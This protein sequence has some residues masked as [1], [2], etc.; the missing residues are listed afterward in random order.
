[1]KKF[2]L[3]LLFLASATLLNAQVAVTVSSSPPEGGSTVPQSG[4][5]YQVEQG[6]E[7]AL[8]AAPADLY[9]FDYWQIDGDAVF[10]DGTKVSTTASSTMIPNGQAT[11]TAYFVRHVAT[12]EIVVYDWLAKGRRFEGANNGAFNL[13]KYPVY[14]WLVMSFDPSLNVFSGAK[15]I[16][17]WKEDKNKYWRAGSITGATIDVIQDANRLQR[18]YIRSFQNGSNQKEGDFISSGVMELAKRDVTGGTVQFLLAKEMK[19]YLTFYTKDSLD[20]Q[21]YGSEYVELKFDS[22]RT[23]LG[24]IDNGGDLN[25][26]VADLSQRLRSKGFVEQQ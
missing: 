20:L 16:T 13:V 4:A 26:T 21:S 7:L 6:M 19:G 8:N 24:N 14:G 22:F 11:V 3:L 12:S 9:D 2:A 5:T 1:M 25:A 15:L 23:Q 10:A 18:I 17:F